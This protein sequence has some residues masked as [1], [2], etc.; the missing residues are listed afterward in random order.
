MLFFKSCWRG[1]PLLFLYLRKANCGETS[2][3]EQSAGIRM[4]SACTARM[5]WRACANTG[6]WRRKSLLLQTPQEQTGAKRIVA[7]LFYVE[8]Q[9]IAILSQGEYH[10]DLVIRPLN[11]PYVL[12]NDEKMSMENLEKLKRRYKFNPKTHLFV[13]QHKKKIQKQSKEYGPCNELC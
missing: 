7:R 6:L 13:R 4:L 8:K 9:D 3:N 12:V 11:Y 1:K 5:T 2:P 10:N